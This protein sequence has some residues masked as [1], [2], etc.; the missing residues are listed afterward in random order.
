MAR[1]NFEAASLC[2]S[3]PWVTS[4]A[5]SRSLSCRS[6]AGWTRRLPFPAGGREGAG[7]GFAA[8][9][10]GGGAPWR[11]GRW[12]RPAAGGW[13]W[14]QGTSLGAWGH[15]GPRY[16]WWV[17]GCWAGC[18]RGQQGMRSPSALRSDGDDKRGQE[19]PQHGVGL[20]ARG[21]GDG[22]SS[23]P[24]S[25][26]AHSGWRRRRRGLPGAPMGG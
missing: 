7:P 24:A 26:P 14:G 13:A 19:V 25:V 23:R 4:L 20:A 10:A 1:P 2:E 21:C 18:R 16:L 6:G 12:G 11:S 9:P 5:R 17:G 22:T 15:G 3:L 8:S